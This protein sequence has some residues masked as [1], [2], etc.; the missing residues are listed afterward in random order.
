MKPAAN[1]PI[2]ASAEKSIEVTRDLTVA[3][4]HANMPEV[5]GT[6]MMIYLMEVA[7]SEAI[8]AYLPEGWVSV[9]VGVD[10]RH[11]AATPVGFTVTAKAEVVAV[12]DNTVTLKVEAY[13]DVEKIGEGMHVRAPIEMARFG[14]RITEKAKK[15]KG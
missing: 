10:I 15:T 6:P 4:F 11:L 8:Q 2:G 12:S 9:G 3:H 13:D 7:S 5:Y 14:K 1:I